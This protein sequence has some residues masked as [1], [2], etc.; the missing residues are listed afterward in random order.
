MIYAI[1]KADKTKEPTRKVTTDFFKNTLGFTD[2]DIIFIDLSEVYKNGWKF[3]A[4]TKE[5]M[6]EFARP[7]FEDTNHSLAK[8]ILNIAILEKEIGGDEYLCFCPNFELTI[9]LTEAF[10]LENARDYFESLA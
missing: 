4:A 6:K 9:Y 10:T 7:I 5:A 8:Q 1:N 2:S 3:S